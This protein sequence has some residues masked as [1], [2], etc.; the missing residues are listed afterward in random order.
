[1]TTVARSSLRL[2]SLESEQTDTVLPAEDRLPTTAHAAA[3]PSVLG[4][5]GFLFK[6]EKDVPPF[7]TKTH[8]GHCPVTFVVFSQVVMSKST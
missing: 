3:T 6:F 5:S 1:M 7:G 8:F 4:A 2:G